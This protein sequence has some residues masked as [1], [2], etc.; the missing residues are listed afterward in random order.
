M[1]KS[2][3]QKVHIGRSTLW[4]IVVLLLV[5]ELFS[6]SVLFTQVSGYSDSRPHTIIDLTQG[7][8]NSVLTVTDKNGAPISNAHSWDDSIRMSASRTVLPKLTEDVIPDP[9]G[10]KTGFSVHDQDKVWTTETDIEI[11]HLSYDDNGDGHITTASGNT[12]KVFAP[13]TGETYPFTLTNSG[14]YN[15]KYYL[16]VEAFYEGTDG[17]WIPIEGRFIDYNNEYIVGTAD[18]WPDVLELN[19]V[20][21]TRYLAPGSKADYSLQWRWVFERGE[22]IQEGLYKGD[23]TE[24]FYDTMLGNTAVDKDLILHIIIRT[25]T[26]ID[27]TAPSPGPNTGDTGNLG[28]WIGIA[29]AALLLMLLVLVFIVKDRRKKRNEE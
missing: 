8:A 16:T 12:F 27:E 28:L 18:E 26:E 21:L 29:V 15:L 1:S 2:N 25:W 22:Q 19:K 23:Y 7:G 10:E 4:I 17:L 11:F 24:D 14:P 9:K 6:L 5:V 13:G 20:S 3:L